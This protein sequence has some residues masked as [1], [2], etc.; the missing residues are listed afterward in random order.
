M[1]SHHVHAIE[2][3]KAHFAH[4]RVFQTTPDFGESAD[5]LMADEVTAFRIEVP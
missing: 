1:R 4:D 2:T 3:P 5:S